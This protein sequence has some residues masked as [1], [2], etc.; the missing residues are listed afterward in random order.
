MHYTTTKIHRVRGHLIGYA[1]VA[2][3][4]RAMLHWFDKE[5]ADPEKY[6]AHQKDKDD[7]CAFIVITPDKKILR[8][9]QTP[10]PS[11]VEDC[12]IAIGS[13]RDYALMAMHLGKSAYEAVTLASLFDPGCGNGVSILHLRG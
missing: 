1:G 2:A 9:E 7:M 3:F 13:G 5:N 4:G 6:P 11:V 12:R 10:Q 8:Y